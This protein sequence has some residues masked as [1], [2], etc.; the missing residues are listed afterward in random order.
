MLVHSLLMLVQPGPLA[1]PGARLGSQLGVHGRFI[2]LD[3]IQLLRQLPLF[4]FELLLL[5]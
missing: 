4:L 1:L 5:F 3:R 2:G